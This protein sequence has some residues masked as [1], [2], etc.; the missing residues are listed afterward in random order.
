MVDRIDID[1]IRQANPLPSI[2][3]PQVRL[4][5]AGN[6]LCGC[7]PFHNDKTPSFYIFDVGRRWICFGCGASGDVLDYVQRLHGVGLVEAARMLGAQELP[8]VALPKWEVEPKA[9]RSEEARA[10]WEMVVP[11]AGTLAEVYLRGRGINPPFPPDIGFAR[12]PYGNLGDLPCMVCA[13][14]DVAGAI[15]GVQRVFLAHDGNGKADVRKPKLSLGRV[16]GGA[17]RMGELD[18][19]GVVIV[20]EGPEDGLSLVE[21][22]GGPVWV[23]TGAGI[24]PAMQ[25]PIEVQRVVIGADN[26]AAGHDAAHKAAAAFIAR[27]LSVRIIYPVELFKDWNAELMG[28]Q[29]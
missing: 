29:S 9:D 19:S 16:A 3:Q 21:M 15:I 4:R 11:A 22:L 6:E 13:V 27:G 26:D 7:C 24:I 17:I 5:R 20:C 12:L 23:A 18:G 25:F 14:R 28:V 10:I 8:T 2:V 1:A